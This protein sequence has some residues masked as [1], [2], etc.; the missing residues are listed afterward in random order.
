MLTRSQAS[1]SGISFH[2]CSIGPR[3]SM[4]DDDRVAHYARATPAALRSTT[5]SL[6]MVRRARPYW[7]ALLA[8]GQ[9]EEV[10]CKRSYPVPAQRRA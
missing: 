6:A 4:T 3:G 5:A 7:P 1:P 9:A 2:A 10:S 8:Q